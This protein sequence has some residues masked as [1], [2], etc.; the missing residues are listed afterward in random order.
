MADVDD[1]YKSK[2]KE[3]L[4]AASKDRDV[5]RLQLYLEPALH[6][7]LKRFSKK[8]ATTMNAVAVIAIEAMLE[9]EHS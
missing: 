6:E 9:I 3:K 7:R 8:H 2:I 1:R 5:R 4:A